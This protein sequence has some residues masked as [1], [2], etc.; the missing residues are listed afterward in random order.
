MPLT[1]SDGVELVDLFSDGMVDGHDIFGTDKGGR[2][3]SE[4]KACDVS[5]IKKGEEMKER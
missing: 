1:V 3:L 5:V 2:I 4:G